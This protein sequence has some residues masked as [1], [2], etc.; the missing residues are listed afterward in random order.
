MDDPRDEELWWRFASTRPQTTDAESPF[1]PM[2][3]VR[4]AVMRVIADR[5][6][7]ITY[8]EYVRK[9]CDQ[10]GMES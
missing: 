7:T 9:W 4:F 1:C 3:P 6:R 2:H 8:D 10:W 5:L